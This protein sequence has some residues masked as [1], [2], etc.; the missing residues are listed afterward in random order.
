MMSRI[1]G[2][3]SFRGIPFLIED[4]QDIN[5]GRRLV[6]HEYPLRNDGLVEDLGKKQRGYDVNCLV[7]G[8]DYLEQAEKL[9]NALEADGKGTLDHPFWGKK[10][11]F[12]ESYRCNSSTASLRVARFS[13]MFYPAVAELAPDTAEDTLFGALDKYAKALETLAEDFGGFIED[14]AIL[15][16]STTD[17]GLFELIDSVV[18]FIDNCF[19]GISRTVG[20]GKTVR[21]KL[22]AIRNR[23]YALSLEPQTLATEIQQ[24]FTLASQPQINRRHIRQQINNYQLILAVIKKVAGSQSTYYDGKNDNSSAKT[25]SNMVSGAIKQELSYT[26]VA[27]LANEKRA[28]Q[29]Q[30]TPLRTNSSYDVKSVVRAFERKLVVYTQT[31]VLMEYGNAVAKAL[32]THKINPQTGRQALNTHIDLVAKS[33]VVHY[34]DELN[35][36]LD[37]TALT[38]ADSGM[39]NS[40]LAVSQYRLALISDLRTRGDTLKKSRQITLRETA[41]ALAV[42]YAQTGNAAGWLQFC[43]R[44]NVRHPLLVIGGQNMEVIDG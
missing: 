37:G 20:T 14:V 31:I 18:D 2:K 4:N 13:I 3:G 22:N 1:N 42:M 29:A 21:K 27:Q 41:P 9:I 36:Q 5:G 39:W 11:V 16:D 32:N 40:Y 34:A 25:E 28:R 26:D 19:R 24:L 10:E 38:F 7:I 33:D 6:S 30:V 23:I 43:K 35:Q 17:N 15:L 8:D 12:V 44:N